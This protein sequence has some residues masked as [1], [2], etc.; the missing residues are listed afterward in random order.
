MK[1]K[2]CSRT[3]ARARLA[4]AREFLDVAELY[5]ASDPEFKRAVGASNAVLA[6]I[7]AADAACCWTLGVRNSDAH[8]EAATLLKRVSESAP[9]GNALAR[10]LSITS[11]VQYVG[12]TS[13]QDLRTA[14]RQASIVVDFADDLIR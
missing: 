4:Q 3:D 14:L 1:T 13:T 9:A 5:R 10:L 8:D 12:K 6:G 2:P 11:K 7:A